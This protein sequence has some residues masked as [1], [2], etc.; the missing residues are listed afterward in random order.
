MV[1]VYPMMKHTYVGP[2]GRYYKPRYKY[3]LI[4]RQAWFGKHIRISVAHGV[5]G[6][7]VGHRKYK[8]IQKFFEEWRLR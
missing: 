4:I 2:A 6:T 5:Q 3:R 1:V 7:Y 8:N